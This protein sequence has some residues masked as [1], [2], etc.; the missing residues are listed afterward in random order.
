[1]MSVVET[2]EFPPGDEAVRAFLERHLA[3]LVARRGELLDATARPAVV[4]FAP[5]GGIAGVLT[6]DLA[7]AECEILTLHAASQ[8]GGVG[9][10]LVEAVRVIAADAGCHTLWVLTTNDNVDALRFYQRRGFRLSALR[11]GAVDEARRTL[12]PRIPLTGS[13]GIPLRDEIELSQP[14]A[15]AAP[16]AAARASTPRTS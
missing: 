3:A 16:G 5:D 7:G 8:W 6:Y 14:V 13:Y 9:T 10:A 11:P 12:K 2:R 4:A 15:A 1:M